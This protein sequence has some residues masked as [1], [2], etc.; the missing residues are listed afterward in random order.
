LIELVWVHELLDIAGCW[1]HAKGETN[2]WISKYK[3]FEAG[4][5]VGDL[6]NLL[7]M[8]QCTASA[9]DCLDIKDMG[10]IDTPIFLCVF[11]SILF[12]TTPAGATRS[13]G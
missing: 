2:A 6:S 4:G 3:D 7:G 5:L 13:I 12:S 10:N 11:N 8:E 1:A 9:A